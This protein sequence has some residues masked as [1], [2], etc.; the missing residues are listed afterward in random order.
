MCALS[1][2]KVSFMNVG[3]L[4]FGELMLRFEHSSLYIFPLMCMKCRS[5]S[6]L[7]TFGWKSILPDI[8]MSTSACFLEQFAWII[9][10]P[11]LYCEIL[12]LTLS[13]VSCMQQNCGSSLCIQ[14][15]SY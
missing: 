2:S 3:A 8:R 13:C 1:F 4:A 10:F 12:S 9:C 11:A 14:A 15:I 5:I 7:M 6:F